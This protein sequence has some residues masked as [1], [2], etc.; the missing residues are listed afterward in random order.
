MPAFFIVDNCIFSLEKLL[1][2]MDCRSDS[3]I[4]FSKYL[5]DFETEPHRIISSGSVEC[6][7]MA[8]A[9]PK[10][11]PYASNMFRAAES[12]RF[13]FLNNSSP[14]IV[15]SFRKYFPEQ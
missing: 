15:C 5:Y 14:L 3:H 13:A 10:F 1:L 12:F 2:R 6:T 7:I 11:V 9:L 8:S 4:D